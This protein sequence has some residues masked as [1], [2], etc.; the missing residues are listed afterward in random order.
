MACPP[1]VSNPISYRVRSL[2]RVTA[3][4]TEEGST[5]PT[6]SCWPEVPGTAA[7]PTSVLVASSQTSEAL[8]VSARAMARARGRVPGAIVAPAVYRS[9]RRGGTPALTSATAERPGLCSMASW[10]LKRQSSGGGRNR[11]VH[12]AMSGTALT[13]PIKAA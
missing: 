6:T 7:A 2:R 11:A 1:A 9:S 3:A 13:G 8:A 12:R 5:T 4:S 10:T